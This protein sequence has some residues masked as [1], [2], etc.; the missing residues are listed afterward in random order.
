[1]TTDA[2]ITGRI[3]S[4]R[5]AAA[6]P[7]QSPKPSGQKKALPRPEAEKGRIDRRNNYFA[8]QTVMTIWPKMSSETQPRDKSFSGFA[9]PC[10]I[11]P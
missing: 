1:M 8:W 5:P 11:G 4:C 7:E 3:S 2:P 10:R 9:N 6:S